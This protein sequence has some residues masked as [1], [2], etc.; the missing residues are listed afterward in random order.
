MNTNLTFNPS[1]LER[2]A[3]ITRK[4]ESQIRVDWLCLTSKKEDVLHYTQTMQ[5]RTRK[6]LNEVRGLWVS[7]N[8]TWG[9]TVYGASPEIET[10]CTNELTPTL[11]FLNAR[12][13]LERDHYNRKIDKQIQ[14]S[15]DHRKSLDVRINQMLPTWEKSKRVS[16]PYFESKVS[17]RFDDIPV[18]V[19][20]GES[21]VRI[22]FAICLISMI[23]SFISYFF[24]NFQATITYLAARILASGLPFYKAVGALGVALYILISFLLI[25]FMEVFH[26]PDSRDIQSFLIDQDDRT[27]DRL[28]E[29]FNSVENINTKPDDLC[30]F[31]FTTGTKVNAEEQADVR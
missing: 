17:Q 2:L 6:L 20:M 29:I 11:L 24:V 30:P 18:L 8:M 26:K 7:C 13:S 27:T 19:N 5:I 25:T 12:L 16:K 21:W 10:T 1:I 31:A 15:V 23:G 3:L 4:L 28:A 22:F 14:D 9:S